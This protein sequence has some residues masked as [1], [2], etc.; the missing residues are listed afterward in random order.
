MFKIIYCSDLHGN[1]I[2]YQKLLDFSVKNKIK[3]IIIGGDICPHAHLELNEAIKFQRDFLKSYLVPLLKKFIKN[4]PDKEFFLM[5]GN[6]DF[7]VNFDLLEKAEKEGLIKILHNRLNKINNKNIVGYSFVSEMPFLL[8]DWEKKDN[9]DSKPL[10][11]PA[12]DIRTVKK[13]KGTIGDDL[14]KLKKL[15]NPERTIYVIHDPPYNTHLDMTSTGEHVGSKAIKEF[16]N[17]EQP[18]LTIHGHI[19]ESH[20]VSGS[21]KEKIGKT[22]SINVGSNHL[23]NKLHLVLIDLDNNKLEFTEL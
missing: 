7:K 15:S 17:K 3:S 22:I 1:K 9:K 16:I 4:N 12:K 11:D 20:I 18:L 21:W 19:H 10:T 13:E 8:K 23:D 6:D 14:K 5:M 2:L